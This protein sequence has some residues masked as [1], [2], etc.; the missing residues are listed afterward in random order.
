M[1]SP[2]DDIE[3]T[4]LF[5][6]LFTLLS[7][8]SHSFPGAHTILIPMYDPNP[9]Y[10]LSM[11]LQRQTTGLLSSTFC[12]GSSA[13]FAQVYYVCSKFT[14]DYDRAMKHFRWKRL[15]ESQTLPMPLN[16]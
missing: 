3:P 11:P 12:S 10:S 15:N 2:K 6:S 14:K 9:F 4:I 1:V 8:F 13:L 7:I 16:F 5:D